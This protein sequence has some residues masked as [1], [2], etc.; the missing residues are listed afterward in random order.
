MAWF[1]TLTSGSLATWSDVYKK[2]IEKFFS[3]QKMAELRTKIISFNQESGEAFYDAWDRFKMLP[4]QCPHH[5][6]SLALLDQSFYNGLTQ[7]SQATVD[8]AAG[9]DTGD[10]MAEETQHLF[11]RLGANSQQK[12]MRRRKRGSDT[13]SNSELAQQVSALTSQMRDFMGMMMNQCSSQ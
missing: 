3:H 6:F 5:G 4:I 12:S 9:G 1:L 10:K 2:F 11:E 13:E 8:N 7:E